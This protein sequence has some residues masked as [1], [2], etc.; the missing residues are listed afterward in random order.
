MAQQI[1]EARVTFF[2]VAARFS[3]EEWKLLH[4]WQKD[5][6]SN[7]MEE[8]QRAFISLGPLIA[9]SV[10]SLRYKD[11]ENLNI[12]DNQDSERH[13]RI[14]H[15][16]Q[17]EAIAP[18]V[19]LVIKEEDDSDNMDIQDPGSMLDIHNATAGLDCFNTE[20]LTSCVD[21]LDVEHREKGTNVLSGFNDVHIDAAD[22]FV[23]HFDAE[24][25]DSRGE[26][27]PYIIPGLEG[28]RSC[29]LPVGT[30]KRTQE[31]NEGSGRLGRENTGDD[32]STCNEKTDERDVSTKS[33]VNV[34][35]ITDET[36][37][38]RQLYSEINLQLAEQYITQCRDGVES[39]AYSGL[40]KKNPKVELSAECDESVNHFR[41][42]TLYSSQ[43]IT[44]PNGAWHSCA[45]C[46]KSF[47]KRSNLLRHQKT[48]RGE[49]LHQCTECEKR[50]TRKMNLL[51]HQ[52]IHTGKRLY[53]CNECEQSFNLKRHLILHQ[54]T[55][56]GQKTYDC[57]TCKQSF[58]QKV[59]LV[60]HQMKHM[61]AQKYKCT[62][63]DK[64]FS[65]SNL[66]V[67]ERT[68]TQE[69]PYQCTECWK[70]FSQK[71]NLVVHKRTHTGEKPYQCTE[72][73]KSFCQK[74]NLIAHKMTHTSRQR[75]KYQHHGKHK[76]CRL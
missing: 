53:Q 35:Q 74:V 36:I 11:K 17:S 27:G 70:S 3:E 61:K 76:A 39:P 26:N 57:T 49:R 9:G 24:E 44:E 12:L 32:S 40:Y 69:K 65:K 62:Q 38:S 73:T 8:I 2:D 67:H 41:D 71:G 29:G 54:R 37:C 59:Q 33:D 75:K 64:S 28:V 20:L 18:I 56:T 5:L 13:H 43:Q 6:Y 51:R 50:F 42:V 21:P 19:S 15:Q 25:T 66:I 1:K 63:C 68:H 58:R 48:H 45:E 52:R 7:V 47:T 60:I 10:F 46:E 4:E 34:L 14:N 23:A 16:T 31:Q 22:H 72:C 30:G 55:H